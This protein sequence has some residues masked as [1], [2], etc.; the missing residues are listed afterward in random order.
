MKIRIVVTLATLALF[1]TFITM[2]SFGQTPVP[3]SFAAVD[4]GPYT[5]PKAS[6]ERKAILD[7]YR[8][9]R[10][11][12]GEDATN[13]VVFVVGY[14]KVHRGWAWITV[15]PQSPSGD[16]KY[17]SESALLRKEDGQWK[18]KARQSSEEGDEDSDDKTF[19]RKLKTRFP[20]MP[21]DIL[22]Q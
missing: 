6:A 5:P 17:E 1:A 10:K 7:A 2:N 22:P 16:Q 18:V 12:P 11:Q 8:E 21:P 4:Q 3:Q 19:F 13:A 20:L 9:A 15:T 14:M